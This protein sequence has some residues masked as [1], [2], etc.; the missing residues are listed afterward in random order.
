MTDADKRTY[1]DIAGVIRNARIA[2]GWSQQKLAAAM[3]DEGFGW[4][5]S[6]V[7]RVETGGR[8]LTWYEVVALA[9]LLGFD[10]DKAA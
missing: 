6:T 9:Q 1:W 5:Q 7:N 2:I 8:E 10:L 3:T 4:Y